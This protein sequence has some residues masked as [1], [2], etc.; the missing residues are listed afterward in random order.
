[1][2]NRFYNA[3]HYADH[4][5][6]EVVAELKGSGDW[7][8]TILLVVPDHGQAFYEHGFPTHGTSLHEEQVRT[9]ALVHAPGL[10]PRVMDEPVSHLDFVPSLLKL[11]GLPRTGAFQGCDAVLDPGYS[12]AGRPL[13]F[14]LQGLVHADGVLLDGW[15]YMLDWADGTE[16]LYHLAADP[17]EREDLL[18][19]GR[20]E[21]DALRERLLRFQRRQVNYYKGKVWSKGFFAPKAD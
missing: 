6:G 15:K 14:S 1:M 3:L 5:V 13:Y 12:A 19:T 10:G 17:G 20:P 2:R 7:D 4:W 9:F 21:E 18:G 11:L 16:R 8:R